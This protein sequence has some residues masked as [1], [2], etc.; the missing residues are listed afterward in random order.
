MFVPKAIVRLVAA[1]ANEIDAR[2]AATCPSFRRFVAR[3]ARR[4]VCHAVFVFFFP[5]AEDALSAAPRRR[6]R[7]SESANELT[8]TLMYVKS[9]VITSFA[10]FEVGPLSDSS[11]FLALCSAVAHH[12]CTFLPPLLSYLP[13]TV[14]KFT[15]TLCAR[16]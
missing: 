3:S 16:R 8:A 13:P 12:R 7:R 1:A 2:S 9:L 15:F 5:F 10:P 14:N 6:H 11:T 4:I